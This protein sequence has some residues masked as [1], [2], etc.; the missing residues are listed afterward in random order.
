MSIL[1]SATV[2]DLW[3]AGLSMTPTSRATLLLSATGEDDVSD[4]TV[5]RRD[6]VLLER[7]CA[8]PWAR[9]AVVDCPGC[10]STLEISFDPIGEVSALGTD[11]HP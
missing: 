9:E 4:W 11:G 8:A 2:L 6:E 3:E 7:Y 10:G 5:G 1:T